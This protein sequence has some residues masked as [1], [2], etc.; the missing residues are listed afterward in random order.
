MR[1]GRARS[2]ARIPSEFHNGVMFCP[3]CRVHYSGGGE[4]GRCP[5]CGREGEPSRS[6]P[7]VDLQPAMTPSVAAAPAAAADAE[8][9][10]TEAQAEAWPPGTILAEKYEVLTQLGSGGFGSVYKVRHVFRK[11]HYALKTPHP[12]FAADDV[13]RRR[14]EREIEAM[15]RFVHPDAV[16]IRDSGVTAEGRPY[17]TMDFIEGESLKDVLRREG[18]LA[19]V[20]AVPIVLRVLR[21]LDVSHSHGIVH[22]DIKPDNIL[23]TGV[24]GREGVKVL[25]FGVAKLLD[26]V[27]ESKNITRGDRVGTPRYMSP[28]QIT[29]EATDPRSDLF[30]LGI[31]FYEMV[32]GSHPFDAGK[33]GVEKAGSLAPL[34]EAIL[35]Q[36][37]AAPREVIPE[38]SKIVSDQILGLLEKRARRRPASASLVIQVLEGAP[39]IASHSAPATR[40]SIHPR[41]P[42]SRAGTLVLGES[43]PEGER[44]CFLFFGDEVRVGR[45]NDPSRGIENDIILR[46]LPCRSRAADPEN[47]ARNLTISHHAATLYPTG[48]ILNIDPAPGVKH[49]IAIGG[50]KS[51]GRIRIQGDRFHLGLGDRAL[52]LD[53]LRVESTPG[54]MRHDLG[55]LAEGRP[56]G[57]GEKART[58]YSNPA[59]GVDSVSL[60]RPENWP[61]HE[62]HIV[63]RALR[64][65]AAAGCAL[66]LARAPA[67]EML[68]IHEAGE[69]FLLPLAKGARVARPASG[70]DTAAEAELSEGTLYPLSPGMR[71]TLGENRF[72]VTLATETDFKTT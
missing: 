47:W 33:K 43:T 52:E 55:F 29:G 28:E 12:E 19:P 38:I 8:R 72:H 35:N 25:D 16:M 68:L 18:R 27:G 34:T 24:N 46:C 37:P 44:R 7:A 61:L 14:F 30:S 41:F 45:S 48:H 57:G 4:K 39:E 56:E 59:C 9:T 10:R 31:V 53:G 22:R 21:V 50:V 64:I 69:A 15:E 54:E 26:L 51:Y 11:K 17:Y 63:C 66:R 49:G 67:P 1:R 58:G 36:T 32:T 70:D 40:L 20:R 62:Y 2:V 3:H 60:Y 65:G 23:L 6:T 42:R 71:L 5:Y 13:F